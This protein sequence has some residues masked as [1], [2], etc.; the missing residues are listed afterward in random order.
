MSRRGYGTRRRR[1]IRNRGSPR[2]DARSSAELCAPLEQDAGRVALARRT[3]LVVARTVLGG[4]GQ[5]LEPV[6]ELED[7]ARADEQV[8]VGLEHRDLVGAGAVDERGPLLR[9]RR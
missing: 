8:A 1:L 7:L 3:M 6:E 5:R 2:C 4:R 9:P